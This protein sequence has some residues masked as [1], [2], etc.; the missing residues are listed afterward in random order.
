VI[1]TPERLL[2]YIL[3]LGLDYRYDRDGQF[4]LAGGDELV[5]LPRNVVFGA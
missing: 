3:K 4:Y 5:E 2:R 1:D